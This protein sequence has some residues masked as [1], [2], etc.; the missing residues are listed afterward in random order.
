MKRAIIP[1]SNMTGLHQSPGIELIPAATV[2]D[3]LQIIR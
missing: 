1:K 2:D 3:A